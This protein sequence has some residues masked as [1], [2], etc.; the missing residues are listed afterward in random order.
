MEPKVADS[1]SNSRKRAS[2]AYIR[3]LERRVASF[4]QHGEHST[5]PQGFTSGHLDQSTD[6]ELGSV[7]DPQEA[8]PP[9]PETSNRGSSP[10]QRASNS[11]RSSPGPVLMNP[12]AHG[13]TSYF[14]DASGRPIYLG[15]SSNWSFGRR[16][17][18]MAHEKVMRAPLPPENLLFQ[19]ESYD[20]GWD[21]ARNFPPAQQPEPPALPSADFATYLISAVKFHCG[22]LFHL[23]EEEV[24]MQQLSAFQEN[25]AQVHQKPSL[26]YIHYLLILAFGKAFVAQSSKGR[27]PPGA[28][29]FVHAMT[30]MPEFAFYNADPIEAIQVLCCA[31]LYLHCLDFRAAAYRMIGQALR[32]ALEHGMHTEMGSQQVDQV[33]AQRCRKVWWTVYVLDR[34]MSSLM[35]V[36]M[37][38]ADELI[39]AELPTFTGQVERSTAMNIQIQLSRILAQILNTVY[40]PEGRLDKR[41]V[42]VTKESLKSVAR[43][44]DQLNG[45]FGILENG[46]QTTISRL[47]AYLHLLYHQCIVLT[48]RPLLFSFLRSRLEQ[49]NANLVAMLKSG[50][51]RMLL[52]MCVE[53]A[54]QMLT[55]LSALQE[56]GLLVSFLP[57]DLDAAFTS[58]IALLMAAKVNSSLV[59]DPAPWLQRSYSVFQEMIY[60]GNMVAQMTKSELE[61]LEG[62]LNRVSPTG[63][64]QTAGRVRRYSGPRV[65]LARHDE[66]ELRFSGAPSHFSTLPPPPPYMPPSEAMSDGFVMDELQWQDGL[67]AEQLVNFAESMDLSALDWL[68]VDTEL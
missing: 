4:E 30:L 36:P 13:F 16:V 33:L 65:S 54:Q 14:A 62:I 34:Q 8:V 45:S 28:E 41:F 50:S 26:W 59:K 58:G 48:T 53:S 3:G 44:T 37:G 1:H 42:T 60:R 52:Q 46:S 2:K 10:R 23:F 43:V 24:F 5:A 18:A 63:E 49:S 68:S 25:P 22:Q 9:Q 64:D 12:L 61:Q 19:G 67:S 11:L 47:S 38:I 7:A 20:L 39:S 40:G 29:F 21:G 17:L 55:I 51:V 35:G 27:K 6:L 56:H 66:R 32:M 57:F 15:T 31:A